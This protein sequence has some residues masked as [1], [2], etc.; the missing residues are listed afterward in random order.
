[1]LYGCFT[2]LEVGVDNDGLAKLYSQYP[3]NSSD[4]K[5]IQGTRWKRYL[6][7]YTICQ[8]SLFHY[9]RKNGSPGFF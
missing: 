8:S 6:G 2:K 9:F 1:M 7:N 4:P 3:K 5:E